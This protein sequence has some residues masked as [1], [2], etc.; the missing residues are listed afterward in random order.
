MYQVKRNR[1]VE[2]LEL[3]DNGK[4]LTLH[5]DMGVDAI[6]Q[7]YT[8]AA[9]VVAAAQ[10]EVR[11]APDNET[12]VEKLG[13]A[14]LKLFEVIFGADQTNQILEF[15]DGAYLEMLTDIAPFINDVVAPKITEAQQRIAGQYA[16]IKTR[17]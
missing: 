3:D 11:N 4:K 9:R 10:Q 7:R 6:L 14:I 17:K 2:D 1:I 5:V 12:K 16:A 13:E 15:Y 8:K